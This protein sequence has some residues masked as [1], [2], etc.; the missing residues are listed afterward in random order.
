MTDNNTEFYIMNSTTQFLNLSDFS[1]PLVKEVEL[2][3]VVLQK[4][5]D[6]ETSLGWFSHCDRLRGREWLDCVYIAAYGINFGTFAFYCGLW[7]AFCIAVMFAIV[8]YFDIVC[9]Y[10]GTGFFPLWVRRCARI[11][12]VPLDPVFADGECVAYNGV[13]E[14]HT[15]DALYGNRFALRRS[16]SRDVQARLE[17]ETMPQPPPMTFAEFCW[18]C[19]TFVQRMFLQ[20]PILTGALIGLL[21][22][23]KNLW[24]GVAAGPKLRYVDVVKKTIMP[25][26]MNVH[27][28]VMLFLCAMCLLDVLYDGVYH[29]CTSYLYFAVVYW[30]GVLISLDIPSWMIVGSAAAWLSVSYFIDAIYDYSLTLAAGKTRKRN[31]LPLVNDQI[32]SRDGNKRRNVARL[33]YIFSRH[34]SKDAVVELDLDGVTHIQRGAICVA[35]FNYPVYCDPATVK[36][37]VRVFIEKPELR[38]RLRRGVVDPETRDHLRPLFHSVLVPHFFALPAYLSYFALVVSFFCQLLSPLS[39]LKT[40]G[41]VFPQ[42]VGES[43]DMAYIFAEEVFNELFGVQYIACLELIGRLPKFGLPALVPFF[44]HFAIHLLPFPVRVVLHFCYNNSAFVRDIE[45]T[46]ASLHFLRDSSVADMTEVTASAIDLFRKARAGDLTGMMLTL[47]MNA[48]RLQSMY[49]SDVIQALIDEIQLAVRPLETPVLVRQQAGT[50]ITSSGVFEEEEFLD[51]TTLAASYWEPPKPEDFWIDSPMLFSQPLGPQPKKLM[52]EE[53]WKELDRQRAP[54]SD[55]NFLYDWVPAPVRRSPTFSKMVALTLIIASSSWFSSIEPLRVIANYMSSDEFQTK[56][57]MA[58]VVVSSVQSFYKGA[59]RVV[60]NGDFMAFFE[61]PKDVRFTIEAHKLLKDDPLGYTVEQTIERIALVR[62][63]IEERQGLTNSPDISRLLEKLRAFEESKEAFLRMHKVRD[64]PMPIWLNGPPGTGKTTIVEAMIHFLANRDQVPRRV[65]DTVNLRI[66]DKFPTAGAHTGARYMVLND[67]PGDYTNFPQ[68]DLMSLELL[69]QKIFDTYPLAFREAAVDAK[70]RVFNDIKYV[71]ITSNHE[72]FVC[73]EETEKLIRRLESGVLLEYDVEAGDYSQFKMLPIGERNDKA[74]FRE[75]LVSSEHKHLKFRKHEGRQVNYRMK[76]IFIHFE[77][78]VAAFEEFQEMCSQQFQSNDRRCACG[79]PWAYHITGESPIMY[80]GLSVR[81]QHPEKIKD[82]YP[83]FAQYYPPRTLGA[84]AFFG[85]ETLLVLLLL[86]FS[87]PVLPQL[88][89]SIVD[90]VSGQYLDRLKEWFFTSEFCDKLIEALKKFVG[91]TRERYILMAARTFYRIKRF[92][93]HNAKYLAAAS[94]LALA[95][96]TW[97]KSNGGED[98][99]EMEL[100]R[101]PIFA[102]DVDPASMDIGIV[103]KIPNY[104]LRERVQWNKKEDVINSVSFVKKNVG[105][106]DLLRIARQNTLRVKFKYVQGASME[107]TVFV[108]SP[109]FVVFNKHYLKRRDGTDL[110]PCA[111]EYEN[112]DYPLELH[113]LKV[114]KHSELVYWRHPFS[115]ANP[116]AHTFLLD[117]VLSVPAD[118]VIPL[119]R[120]EIRGVGRPRSHSINGQV[121]SCIEVPGE[122]KVGDCSTPM[123]ARFDGGCAI[124]GFVAYGGKRPPFGEVIGA[125]MMSR[126]MMKEDLED[127]PLPFIEDVSIVPLGGPIGDLSKNSALRAV[128]SRFLLTVGTIPGAGATFTSNLR[129]TRLHGDLAHLLSEPYAI[130]GKTRYVDNEGTFHTPMTHTFKY[131]NEGC[132]VSLPRAQMYAQKRVRRQFGALVREKGIRLSPLDLV[133][134][135]FG[136]EALGIKRI[137]FNTSVGPTLKAKGMSNKYDMFKLEDPNVVLKPEVL[138]EVKKLRDKLAQFILPT[139]LIDMTIK[140]EVRPLDKVDVAKLRIFSVMDTPL[141]LLARCYLMPLITLL[142]DYRERSECYGGMNAGSPE[143]FELAQRIKGK[144]NR[145]FFDMDFSAFDTSHGRA[146]VHYVACYF[147]FLSLLCGYTLE[148]A[149]MVYV[150]IKILDVQ[151]VKFFGDLFIKLKGMPSGFLATLI[152]NSLVN[153]WLL[154]MAFDLLVTDG[155]YERDV[156]TANVGDDNINGVEASIGRVFNML[157][158]QPVYKRFGYIVTPAKKGGQMLATIKFEDLTFLKRTFSPN[159]EFGYLAPLAKDSLIKS[160]CF[161]PIKSGTSP[162]ARLEAAYENAL[163][164]SFLHG[165]EYFM[166]F[167]KNVGDVLIKHQLSPICLDF[168]DLRKAYAERRFKTTL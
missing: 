129:P 116:P 15:F 128:P 1:L 81:C 40:L 144:G 108:L 71:F 134:S 9:P 161:E 137:E 80:R 76:D 45:G 20:H 148:E 90:L 154:E 19:L 136:E 119:E 99:P 33:N 163:R 56:G 101:A 91:W 37:F 72:T 49:G 160:L 26:N 100:L 106:E 149:A 21:A 156:T 143:W 123:L 158:I 17:R 66:D 2:P 153:G 54:V 105:E 121:Y 50:A 10:F 86:G 117:E 13:F 162:A 118:V 38:D 165:K 25:K 152:F 168:D 131:I 16:F 42:T 146:A 27:L 125:T 60:E 94:A 155:D 62:L 164:E 114:S 55:R 130:P 167:A 79:L 70:G 3:F 36:R 88:A 84:A 96:F 18:F 104:E 92:L 22:A 87:R 112:V 67:I 127:D 44:F 78:R 138:E 47:G 4:E 107:T 140:D 147:Y 122:G 157:T 64:M 11:F 30:V 5:K 102:K 142:L 110:F 43:D 12:H 57:T 77:R 63:L 51:M 98:D 85:P 74:V 141:N 32:I 111:V 132:S 97:W 53:E 139:P 31:E 73:C 24:F 135:V 75:L 48:N 103:R 52:T 39:F 6:V 68:R 46:A 82:Q 89:D 145:V 7:C 83:V 35:T 23:L 59:L 69:L 14:R 28:K 29:A 120:G 113:G 109:D 93:V 95:V 61:V 41:C 8:V 150:L 126:K 58:S 65:G 166:W 34:A 133:Q 115:L 124:V 159:E 151:L